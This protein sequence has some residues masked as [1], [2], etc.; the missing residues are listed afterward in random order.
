MFI[1][2]RFDLRT[3]A[4]VSATTEDKKMEAFI[5]QLEHQQMRW[6]PADYSCKN[7]SKRRDVLLQYLFLC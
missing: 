5:A 1:V 4:E 3:I 2:R 7:R 6:D